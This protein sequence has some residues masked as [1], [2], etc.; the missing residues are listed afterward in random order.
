MQDAVR[1]ATQ[2]YCILSITTRG[3]IEGHSISL[4]VSFTICTFT[5]VWW[6]FC[7]WNLIISIGI[8]YCVIGYNYE[9]SSSSS[10]Y[11]LAHYY[12]MC[13]HF[14]VVSIYTYVTL[15]SHIIEFLKRVRMRFVTQ[16]KYTAFSTLPQEV[17]GISLQVRSHLPLFGKFSQT[18][19][20]KFSWNPCNCE[21]SVIVK[22]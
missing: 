7:G 6:F 13:K 3:A 14:Q 15:I 4:Q 16:C 17:T 9:I 20:N 19:S 11:C 12:S 18:K 21:F 22:V 8:Q 5:I 10:G 1:N 2:V